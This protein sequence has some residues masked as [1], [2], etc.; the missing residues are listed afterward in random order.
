MTALGEVL[1]INLYFYIYGWGFITLP[2]SLI[3]SSQGSSWRK[4]K[5]LSH[6][7]AWES[8]VHSV[9]WQT[10]HRRTLPGANFQIEGTKLIV[11]ARAGIHSPSFLVLPRPH[12]SRSACILSAVLTTA[13]H[14]TGLSKTLLGPKQ[15]CCGETARLL[16]GQG[17]WGSEG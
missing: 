13:N 11:K 7:S 1:F 14:L 6:V 2:Y 3:S 9:I 8:D 4:S 12:H 10:R 16:A 17:A 5:G 15:L